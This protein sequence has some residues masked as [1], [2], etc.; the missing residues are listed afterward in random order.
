[1]IEGG[2]CDVL[3]KARSSNQN[4]LRFK[5]IP[6]PLPPPVGM[7]RWE[8]ITMGRLYW[9]SVQFFNGPYFLLVRAWLSLFLLKSIKSSAM[10]YGPTFNT[11]M[12]KSLN[13]DVIVLMR[14]PFSS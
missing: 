14:R 7:Q 2:V 8:A 10:S 6:S 11:R 12:D 5:L 4:K 13:Y 1:M 9:I 3:Y